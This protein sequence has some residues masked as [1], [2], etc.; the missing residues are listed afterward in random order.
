MFEPCRRR[1][2]SV[3][4]DRVQVLLP[5][6]YIG[7]RRYIAPFEN[8]SKGA[9]L[10]G[11]SE[12]FPTWWPK[13][14]AVRPKENES[15]CLAEDATTSSYTPDQTDQ[16]P[17]FRDSGLGTGIGTSSNG[18]SRRDRAFQSSA[19]VSSNQFIVSEKND[20]L[21]GPCILAEDPCANNEASPFYT[22]LSPFLRT[23]HAIS[24]ESGHAQRNW[25]PFRPAR[26]ERKGS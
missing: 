2:C 4:C 13:N 25:S 19:G 26:R 15:S 21:D 3:S 23:C 7:S 8:G 11:R 5:K 22:S 9:M 14:A 10:F 20:S 6:F 17:P 12:R 24:S 16:T 1:K 18:G